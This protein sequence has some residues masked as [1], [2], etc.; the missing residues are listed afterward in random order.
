LFVAAPDNTFEFGLHA[1]LDSLA[2]R[3]R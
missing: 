1:T 2:A 3:A